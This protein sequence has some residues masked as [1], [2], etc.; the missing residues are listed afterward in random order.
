MSRQAS[1]EPVGDGV[2]RYG[3]NLTVSVHK[4]YDI[5]LDAQPLFASDFAGG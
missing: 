5:N 4:F 1:V 3:C 2:G